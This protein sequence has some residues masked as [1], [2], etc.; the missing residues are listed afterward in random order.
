MAEPAVI[1]KR[2]N[3][4]GPG[5]YEPKTNMNKI[6]VYS[7]S[8]MPNSK[9]QAWSPSKKRFEDFNKFKAGLPGPADYNSSDYQGGVYVLSTHKNLGNIKI[10]QDSSRKFKNF[11]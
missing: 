10:S 6:G 2:K 5:T 11:R 8:T 9:A 3:I 7:V 4:P 1:N